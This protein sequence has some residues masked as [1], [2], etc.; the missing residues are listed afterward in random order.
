M[1]GLFGLMTIRWEK[2]LFY[3]P[4]YFTTNVILCSDKMDLKI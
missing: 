1:G 2:I 4:N 3:D